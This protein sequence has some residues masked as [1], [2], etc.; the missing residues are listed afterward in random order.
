MDLKWSYSSSKG[1]YIGFK[2]TF[3]LDYD[4]MTPVAILFH[5]GAPNDAKL[6]EEI[7]KELRR[8]RIIRKQDTLIFDK[9]YYSLTNYQIGISKYQIVPLIFPKKFLNIKHLDDVLSYSLNIFKNK[10]DLNKNKR[11][12]KTIKKR[13]NQQTNKLETL[14]TYKM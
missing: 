13:I 8:R 6:F 7:M 5:S 12:F 11:L 2:A 3:I 1:F 14:Q 4:F 9:G 10:K